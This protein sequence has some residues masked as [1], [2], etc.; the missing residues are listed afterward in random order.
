M[1]FFPEGTRSK[2]G[3]LGKFKKGAFKMACD[4]GLPILP[5]TITG[6]REIVQTKSLLLFPGRATMT[7]HPPVSS[8]G[9][10]ET[11]LMNEV[12]EIMSAALPD[13][14]RT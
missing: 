8:L 7:V 3:A 11:E 9:K 4:L 5:V 2:T 6:T 13:P 1:I 14:Q 12:R 10:S